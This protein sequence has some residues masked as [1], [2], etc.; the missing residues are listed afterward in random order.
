MNVNDNDKL[1]HVLEKFQVVNIPNLKFCVTLISTPTV[2][3][4]TYF[5]IQ[6]SLIHKKIYMLFFVLFFIHQNKAEV[7]ILVLST[8]EILESST[9][10][11]AYHRYTFQ[12]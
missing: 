9:S 2:N 12:F 10:C 6:N 4:T 3:S 8:Y 5:D 11:T 7:A 1:G